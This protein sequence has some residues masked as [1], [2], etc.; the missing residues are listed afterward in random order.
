MEKDTNTQ[1]NNH[2]EALRDDWVFP[3][4][5]YWQDFPTR[6]HTSQFALVHNVN[7][8]KGDVKFD[9]NGFIARP[10][11]LF[12]ERFARDYDV[13]YSATTATAT[14]AAGIC[15]RALL[16]RRRADQRSL[17]RREDEINAQFAAF[18]CRRTVT[19]SGIASRLCGRAATTIPST[20]R[21]RASTR[22]SRIRSS[23]VRTRASG[24]VSRSR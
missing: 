21:P 7:R 9:D 8:E 1:L 23:P 3:A 12:Q 4:N 11:S 19:G 18:D 6:G 22:S 5:L 15:P 24:F 2:G 13:T 16:G 20:T 10:A 17:P 14:S